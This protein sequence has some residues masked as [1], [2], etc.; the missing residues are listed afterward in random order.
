MKW[1]VVVMLAACRPGSGSFDRAK[2][3]A[4]V[5]AVRPRLVVA[6]QHYRFQLNDSLDASSLAIT[7]DNAVMGRGD[8][9]GRVRAVA[10]ADHEIAVSIETAD[11]GHAGEAGFMY[12]DD[13]FP[14]R[15]LELT[16]LDS[17]HETRIDDHWV[18]WVYDMD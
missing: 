11:H 3:D 1:V 14:K 4:I 9:R 6:G 13:N 7:P 15:E 12:V 5:A 17:Q 10:T 8:G 2:Y 16:Q 18:S